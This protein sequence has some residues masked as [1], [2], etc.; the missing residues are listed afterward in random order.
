MDLHNKKRVFS[1]SIVNQ[2]NNIIA[3]FSQ[4]D[5]KAILVIL[6]VIFSLVFIKYFSNLHTAADILKSMGI[7]FLDNYRNY[8]VKNLDIKYTEKIYWASINIFFY[9]FLPFILILLYFKES[10]LEYGFRNFFNIRKDSIK[11]YF[12][13]LFLLIPLVY[14]VSNQPAFLKKYP[15]YTPPDE[16]LLWPK[17]IIWEGFYL[18]Q[19]IALEFFFRGFMIQGLK[20]TFGYY[21][22]FIML[23][24]YCMIHFQK[25]LPETIGAVFAGLALGYLSLK[26]NS[27]SLGIAL[28]YTVAIVMD[29]LALYNKGNL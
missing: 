23:I 21:S 13:F 4:L 8:A 18:L 20:K 26:R 24:P 27:I 17:F 3:D 25:P 16:E 15:F 2:Y 1:K 9:L 28:H 12:L 5:L 6:S 7:D 10:L 29:L 14:L 19:F 11:W 22:I